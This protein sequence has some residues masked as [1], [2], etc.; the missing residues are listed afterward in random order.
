[1]RA[2][3]RPQPLAGASRRSGT[4]TS[5]QDWKPLPT[6]KELRPRCAHPPDLFGSARV[7]KAPAVAA[8]MLGMVAAAPESL[9]GLR[10][11]ALLL[12]GFAGALRRSELDGADISETE[13]GLLVTIRGSKTDQE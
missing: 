12:I 7:R 3:R 6:R 11:R 2:R 4:L 8:K 10:D 5:W 13:T 9:A 1:M